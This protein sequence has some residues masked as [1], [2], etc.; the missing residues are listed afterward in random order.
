MILIPEDIDKVIDT[1]QNSNQL[2]VNATYSI[3]EIEGGERETELTTGATPSHQC[4]LPCSCIIYE[5]EGHIDTL[6]K[7]LMHECVIKFLNT[8]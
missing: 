2:Q 5:L 4:E 3:K 7:I 6:F 1:W 8:V